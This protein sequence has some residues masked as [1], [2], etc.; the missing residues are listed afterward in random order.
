MTEFLAAPCMLCP[1]PVPHLR[2]PGP[3]PI[4]E[5]GGDQD[6]G[7]SWNHKAS[8]P[9]ARLWALYPHAA[10]QRGCDLLLLP[11]LS[12]PLFEEMRYGKHPSPS[13]FGRGN[14]GRGNG[15]TTAGRAD[16][17][18]GRVPF[19]PP[20]LAPGPALLLS[21]PLPASS[22]LLM[23]HQLLLTLRLAIVPP[24]SQENEAPSEGNILELHPKPE[25]LPPPPQ[26]LS[27]TSKAASLPASP[28]PGVFP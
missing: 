20:W 9:W 6:Q 26:A 22:R 11:A 19:G 8:G 14:G 17:G 7:H 27:P 21:Q 12:V 15:D 16:G 28:D 2:H 24:T 3:C 1:R 18:V 25:P 23:P 5:P 13:H 4:W 10:E